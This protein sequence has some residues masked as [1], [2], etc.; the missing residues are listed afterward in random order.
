[1]RFRQIARAGLL[2]VPFLALLGQYGERRNQSYER[3]MQNPS[4]E[5]PPDAWVE[6][7]YAFARLRYQQYG[8][9]GRRRG[10]GW[11]TDSNKAER[12]FMQGVRRLTRVDARSVEQIIDADSDEVFKWPWLYAV[13]VGH[14]E[15]TEA[16]AK[17]LRD[18]LLRGGFLMVDDFHGSREWEVFTA[19]L[20][21]VFPD[22]QI[23]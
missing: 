19:S 17:R 22:R 5:D 9:Y 11:G 15:L 13:E 7:E 12:H 2:L 21:R 6:G 20:Q 14:W 10:G 4:Y 18:Y 23:V 3:E 16:H 8:G 1:M